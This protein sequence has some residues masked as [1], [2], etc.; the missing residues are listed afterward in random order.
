MADGF[1]SDEQ[2]R[3]FFGKLASGT[4]GARKRKQGRYNKNPSPA[5][6]AAYQGEQ[7]RLLDIKRREATEGVHAGTTKML[8]EQRET[9]EQRVARLVALGERQIVA[10]RAEVASIAK[11]HPTWK[12]HQV[13]DEIE[14]RAGARLNEQRETQAMTPERGKFIGDSGYRGSETHGRLGAVEAQRTGTMTKAQV[15]KAIAKNEAE[16]R[17]VGDKL[18]S[19]GRGNERYSETMSKTDQLSVTFRDVSRRGEA[20]KGQLARIDKMKLKKSM[21]RMGIDVSVPASRKYGL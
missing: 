16:A 13:E 2:R 10:A 14:R 11:Q 3:A 5:E 6:R 9:N 8:N 7:Q 17:S 4:L 12:T 15:Q 19:T 21:R 20:L 18:I 1:D